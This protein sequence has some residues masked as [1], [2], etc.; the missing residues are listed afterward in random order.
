MGSRR[1]VVPEAYP[2]CMSNE[3]IHRIGELYDAVIYVYLDDAEIENLGDVVTSQTYMR[4]G[5]FP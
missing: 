3:W 2:S 4:Y 1:T 5:E